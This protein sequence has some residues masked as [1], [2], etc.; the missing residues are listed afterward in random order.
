MQKNTEVA[1]FASATAELKLEQVTLENQLKLAEKIVEAGLRVSSGHP[2]L[3]ESLL[4]MADTQEVGERL[5][6]E[7]SFVL[8]F[9]K[10]FT[11]GCSTGLDDIM[12]L[13]MRTKENIDELAGDCRVCKAHTPKIVKAAD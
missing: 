8:K 13:R 11:T 3:R 5:K 12:S 4:K 9:N 2:K 10:S 1:T 6:G 7:L